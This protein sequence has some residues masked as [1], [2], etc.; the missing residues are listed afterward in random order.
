MSFTYY[1]KLDPNASISGA[2]SLITLLQPLKGGDHRER[3]D[4]TENTLYM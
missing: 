3:H 2:F 1:A 4:S